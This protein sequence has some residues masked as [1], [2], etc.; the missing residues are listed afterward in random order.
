MFLSGE[1]YDEKN[2]TGSDNTISIIALFVAVAFPLM[3]LMVAV[4]EYEIAKNILYTLFASILLY[5]GWIGYH[6]SRISTKAQK[7]QKRVDA[8]EKIRDELLRG[9]LE[10]YDEMYE[11]YKSAKE[12]YFRNYRVPNTIPSHATIQPQSPREHPSKLSRIHSTS[13]KTDN[14]SAK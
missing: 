10:E 11:R 13:T 3:A 4:P 8:L 9:D 7:S 1:I 14:P 12:Q 6:F 2:T 5:F